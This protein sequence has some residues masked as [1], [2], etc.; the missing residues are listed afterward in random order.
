MPEFG[1]MCVEPGEP[2]CEGEEPE[3][4]QSPQR[5]LKVRLSLFFDG[6]QN[7]RFNTRMRLTEDKDA[8]AAKIM[9]RIREK[10]KD[11]SSSYFNEFS[12]VARLD[13]YVD[14]SSAPGYDFYV[15]VYIEGIGTLDGQSDD[16]IGVIS[17]RLG[18]GVDKKVTKGLMKAVERVLRTIPA[19]ST[20]ELLSVDTFGF[21]RGAAA[22]R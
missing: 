1:E 6:T 19:G 11:E 16:Q 5:P 22:A 3:R 9:Q 12:N 17:G 8:E 14:Q 21:S 15:K 18:T 20:I 2:I 13:E 10:D 7:N 4:D